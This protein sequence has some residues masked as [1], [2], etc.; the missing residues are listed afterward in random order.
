MDFVYG[1]SQ[2]HCDLASQFPIP[3]LSVGANDCTDEAA[4]FA[5]ESIERTLQ[6]EPHPIVTDTLEPLYRQVQAPDRDLQHKHVEASAGA[7]APTS[8]AKK[9]RS[10]I[11]C[12]ACHDKRV[13]CDAVV[14]GLPCSNCEDRAIECVFRNSKRSWYGGFLF[15]KL[16]ALLTAALIGADAALRDAMRTVFANQSR[17]ILKS[18]YN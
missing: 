10:S 8:G 9:K 12:R 5:F 11:A 15:A 1:P 6:A 7:P 4:F 16:V 2:Q 3:D 14:R 13:R 17:R 18:C